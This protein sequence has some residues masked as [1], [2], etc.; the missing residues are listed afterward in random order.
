LKCSDRVVCSEIGFP[1]SF[2]V[3]GS[4]SRFVSVNQVRDIQASGY[5]PNDG[6]ES[7]IIAN[8]PPGNCTAIVR[9]VNNI[10]GVGLVE[11]YEFVLISALRGYHV[12]RSRSQP[13]LEDGDVQELHNLSQDLRSQRA[14]AALGYLY[15]LQ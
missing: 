6:R 14:T 5:A 3:L 7:A 12:Q 1:A 13:S 10:T 8:L 2:L 15:D 11:V 9:S 4:D